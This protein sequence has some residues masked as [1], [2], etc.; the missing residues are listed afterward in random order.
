MNAVSGLKRGAS[1]NE[2]Y[3]VRRPRGGGDLSS[4]YVAVMFSQRRSDAVARRSESEDL[5]LFFLFPTS[6]SLRHCASISC[7]RLF[8]MD[9]RLPR[10]TP[11]DHPRPRRH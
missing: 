6:A 1:K 5:F 3:I 2:A 10:T 7:R 8:R 4:A 9:P 11:I